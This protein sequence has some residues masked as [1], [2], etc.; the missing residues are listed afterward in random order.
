MAVSVITLFIM[1]YILVIVDHILP[2]GSLNLG[3]YD[4][5]IG[6]FMAVFIPSVYLPLYKA[7][8]PGLTFTYFFALA[9]FLFIAY[10]AGG[11]IFLVPVLVVGGSYGS[12]RRLKEYKNPNV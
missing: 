9:I 7:T 8:Y 1:L 4:Y 5:I 12:V 6:F 3:E 11:W 10:D 2:S